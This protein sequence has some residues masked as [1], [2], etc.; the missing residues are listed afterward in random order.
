MA[1]QLSNNWE[2]QGRPSCPECGP[3]RPLRQ[4]GSGAHGQ[5]WLADGPEG[6]VA[7]KVCPR[8]S[9][10]ALLEDWR[11]EMRGW[12]LFS[13]IPRHEAL[14]RVFATGATADNCAFW[15]AM[16]LADAEESDGAGN[17]DAYRPKTLASVADAEI[18][19][20]F[21]DCLNIGLRLSAALEHLQR[22]HLLHR[23][24]KP[25]N[26]LYVRGMP[27]IADA[28]LVVDAREADSLVGTPGYVP[29]ENH[30]TPQGDVFSLGKTL[31]RI[32]T[33]RSPDAET[34]APC[35]E[36]DTAEPLF[37]EFMGILLRAMSPSPAKR[38]R[39]AKALRKA[40]A[41]LRRKMAS[42][43]FERVTK[44]FLYVICL[45]LMLLVAWAYGRGFRVYHKRDLPEIG[46]DPLAPLR[47]GIKSGKIHLLSDEEAEAIGRDA[48]RIADEAASNLWESVNAL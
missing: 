17:P 23:D 22:H 8:P 48:Q 44:P 36:A 47:E 39:S 28:G 16:E 1:N 41:R 40:L 3:Y 43:K 32:A 21:R 26:I 45:A 4:I 25:G 24:I 35:A 10:P 37:G 38:F 34:I 6:R 33:G 30:G 2:G 5:V 11:R 31:W 29:P 12:G 20:P 7:L 46:E 9:D 15:V 14:V 13:A 18:A 42:R 19:L 27:V